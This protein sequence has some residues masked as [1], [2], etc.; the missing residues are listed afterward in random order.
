MK[1]DENRSKVSPPSLRSFVAGLFE[2]GPTHHGRQPGLEEASYRKNSGYAVLLRYR[3]P[4][5]CVENNVSVGAGVA[6]FYRGRASA[7]FEGPKRLKESV[8]GGFLLIHGD[9][10]DPACM[11]HLDEDIGS[12]VVVRRVGE[13]HG[14]ASSF[15]NFRFK[16]GR[17]LA[18]I[19]VAVVSVTESDKGLT[20]SA[21]LPVPGEEG[22]LVVDDKP[23]GDRAARCRGHRREARH[24]RG[25]VPRR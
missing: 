23:R 14:V 16:K 18:F 3:D 12:A 21:F 24:A 1:L 17:G 2:A 10:L 4:L 20:G 25:S 19:R 13:T 22:V 9:L 7:E 15:F 8:G 11:R 6:H 5:H